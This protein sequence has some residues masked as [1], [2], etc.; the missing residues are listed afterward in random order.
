[1]AKLSPHPSEA[2]RGPDHFRSARSLH[3]RLVLFCSLRAAHHAH[4]R[5]GGATNPHRA[6]YVRR[7]ARAHRHGRQ[8][9]HRTALATVVHCTVGSQEN[10]NVIRKPGNT[11]VSFSPA[12]LGQI[13]DVVTSKDT[14]AAYAPNLL[15]GRKA[16]QPL[17]HAASPCDC[18]CRGNDCPKNAQTRM[19]GM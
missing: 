12:D 19:R 16:R 5:N 4:R 2:L 7:P 15:L 1:M 18:P 13:M 14:P 10:R 6:L 17:A 9:T 3:N 11:P 8:S